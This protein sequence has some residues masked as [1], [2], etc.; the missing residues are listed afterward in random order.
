M[1]D[2]GSASCSAGERKV[3]ERP[4]IAFSVQSTRRTLRI[5]DGCG[6]NKTIGWMGSL[7]LLVNNITGPAMISM[8]TVFGQAG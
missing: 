7:C 6:G 5:G 4:I 2:E 8:G 1:T 3:S